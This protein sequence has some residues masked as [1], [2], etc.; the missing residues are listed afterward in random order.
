MAGLFDCRLILRCGWLSL[1]G[2]RQ[3]VDQTDSIARSD[4]RHFVLAVGIERGVLRLK[5]GNFAT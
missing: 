3:V 2:E 1:A 5:L 4:W